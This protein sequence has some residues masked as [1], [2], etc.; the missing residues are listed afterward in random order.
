MHTHTHTHAY[1]HAHT[2]THTRTH[3]RRPLKAPSE[4]S[5]E[6]EWTKTLEGTEGREGREREATS[7]IT[8]DQIA[9]LKRTVRGLHKDVCVKDVLVNPLPGDTDRRHQ[10]LEDENLNLKIRMRQMEEAVVVLRENAA[11]GSHGGDSDPALRAELSALSSETEQKQAELL[12][13][14]REMLH[15]T[16]QLEESRRQNE[17]AKAEANKLRTQL[18]SARALNEKYFSLKGDLWPLLTNAATVGDQ[19]G[20]SNSRLSISGC[21]VRGEEPLEL[22]GSSNGDLQLVMGLQ[23]LREAYDQEMERALF[24]D[25]ELEGAAKQIAELVYTHIYIYI[26]NIYIPIY[27]AQ[28]WTNRTLISHERMSVHFLVLPG[29]LLSFTEITE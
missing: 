25:N 6:K 10:E 24:L 5:D 1:T 26:I 7:Y 3:G 12:Q 14:R 15:V 18:A 28:E 4:P 19:R 20:N 11:T 8:A 29:S 16:A 13:V 17:G 21:N 27:A 2:C 22:L 23:Q 9:E